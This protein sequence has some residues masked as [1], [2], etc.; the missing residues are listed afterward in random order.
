MGGTGGGGDGGTPSSSSS[1]ETQIQGG[2]A[3]LAH[4]RYKRRGGQESLASRKSC[5]KKTTAQ[6]HPLSILPPS[7]PF[8]NLPTPSLPLPTKTT[9]FSNILR[10][11]IAI[12]YEYRQ[13]HIKRQK[14]DEKYCKENTLALLMT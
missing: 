5:S 8:T 12:L 10:Y 4:N 6:Q 2:Q 1:Q 13:K 7:L 9:S 3:R 14:K 11:T